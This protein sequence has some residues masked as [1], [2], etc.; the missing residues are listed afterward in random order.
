MSKRSKNWLVW[1]RNENGEAIFHRQFL[2][3]TQ[4][5]EEARK[6]KGYVKFGYAPQVRS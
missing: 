6:I 1:K 5:R 3:E 2:I 4:A